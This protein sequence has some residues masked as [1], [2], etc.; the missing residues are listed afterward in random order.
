LLW[1]VLALVVF[2]APVRCAFAQVQLPADGGA[3]VPVVATS[4]SA[5]A[6]DAGDSA[7]AEVDGGANGEA[8]PAA[9]SGAEI[10]S[11]V[12]DN[13]PLLRVLVEAESSPWGS[14][15]LPHI[16]VATGTLYSGALARK[17]LREVTGTGDFAEAQVFSQREPAGVV[18]TIRVVPRKIVQDI[19][20]DFHGAKIAREDVLREADLSRDQE[21]TARAFV[22]FDE[23]IRALFSRHGYVNAKTVIK[24]QRGIDARHIILSI[25][26]VP[27]EPVLIGRRVI[28]ATSGD[29][30]G[31]AA[32]LRSYAVDQGDVAD[33]AVLELADTQLQGKLRGNGFH[34]AAV[35][36]KLASERGT[37]TLRVQVK[38]GP[39]R[40]PSFQGNE[41]YDTDVLTAALGLEQDSDRAPN[42]LVDKLR[43]FYRARGFLDVE[44]NFEERTRGTDRVLHFNIR[45]ELRVSL[46][47]RAYPCLPSAELDATAL[48]IA[49]KNAKAIGS[50][51]DSFL[52]EELPGSDFLKSPRPSGLDESFG[53]APSHGAHTTPILLNPNTTFVPETYEHAAAHLQELYRA[54]GFL[55]AVV[56]PVQVLRARCDPKSPV[57]TCIA[58]AIGISKVDFCTFD[59]RG[60]PKPAPAPDPTLT[61]VAD[62]GRG[63]LCAPDVEVQLPIKLGPRTILYDAAFVGVRT[64]IPEDLLRETKLVFGAPLNP[65][66]IEE[67]RKL[68]LERYKEEGFF[69]ASIRS[70]LEKSS[71]QTRARVSFAITEGERVL[72]RAIVIRGNTNVKESVIRGR[73]AFGT[74]DPYRT[75]LR[76]KSE[77]RM[78]TLN[79]FSGVTIDLDDPYVPERWKTVVIT[80]VERPR[81]S[82]D[83]SVGFSTAE[84]V[85]GSFDGEIRNVLG[86]AITLSL[87]ARLSYP[88]AAAPFGS[89]FI[90]DVARENFLS[91]DV[92]ARA[93][94]R[95]TASVQ[96]PETGLGPMFRG[97]LDLI[98]THDLQRD[99]Y[100]RKFAAVPSLSFAP[101]RELRVTVSQ[102]IEYNTARVFRS[103][104][105]AL[106]RQFAASGRRD[107]LATLLVPEGDSFVSAQKIEFAW[108]RRDSASNPARGTFFNL[109]VEHVDSFALQDAARQVE[110]DIGRDGHFFHIRQRFSG[111][112]PIYKRL[113]LAADLTLGANLR[114]TENSKTYPD[115]LFFMGGVNS[116]RGW[117]PSTFIPQDDADLIEA[118]NGNTITVPTGGPRGST[119]IPDPKRFTAQSRAVRGGNLVVNPHIELRIPVYGP[120]ETVAF[121]D[122]GNLWSNQDYPLTR[123][124]F[125]M[126]VALGTGIRLLTPVF[127]IVFDFGFNP[128][129]RFYDDRSWALNFAIGLF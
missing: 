128:W 64:L 94:A 121:A 38:L 95:I 78:L 60:L 79:V 69:Y 97:V 109:S 56:G 25:E 88:L 100:V 7:T 112:I 72:V 8:R 76:R 10:G 82:T 63:V 68:L 57:G 117:F 127:P 53:N 89:L 30:I 47:A 32:V 126:R 14:I 61:C 85:R 59:G 9:T 41:H 104:I 74:G 5:A 67:A 119:T 96:F 21:V 46:R 62:P 111:Y 27:G 36:H 18:L 35:T 86:R 129:K 42:Q 118:E 12:P 101:S 113:R 114:I 24:S 49:P 29:A 34:E 52:E 15:G 2:S 3:R 124:E 91:A 102:S 58:Q 90:D 105:D 54:D 73:L 40:T 13:T 103:N 44:V 45:E 22:T 120:L 81:Y 122:I 31:A 123:G 71:D 99:Y 92:T 6:A 37:S 17:Y 98:G 65:V 1:C 50:E 77:E 11:A 87:S 115:R 16:D 28:E 116:M 84:G 43:A 33:E 19:V 110:A 80:V 48:E 55:A 108:D 26:V 66:R 106:Q 93:P 23:R 83:V 4:V 125:P 39:R 51:I 75:S 20:T 107:L 70:N